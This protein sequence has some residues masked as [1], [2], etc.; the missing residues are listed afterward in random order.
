MIS[1]WHFLVANAPTLVTKLNQHI[2]LSLS[3]TLLAI[4]IGLPLGIW[5]EQKARVRPII[6]GVVNI[7]QTIPSLAL[8]A[9]FIPLLGIG[10]K[11][12]IITLSIYA[13]LPIVRNTYLGLH[14]VPG[15]SIE[16]ARAMGFTRWQRLRI[17][18][19]PLAMPMI[20]AGIR[21]AV[22]MNI[23]ITTIAAFI[24]AGG[25]GDFITEGLAMNNTR[26]ILLGAIPAALLA[27]IADY[28]IAQ[29]EHWA[30]KRARRH[31]R[32]KIVKLGFFMAAFLYFLWLLV[33]TS[34][35]LFSHARENTLIVGGKNFTEQFILTDI[36]G[37][38]LR[39]HTHLHVVLKPNLGS[40]TIA[41][42]ALMSGA[43]DMYPEY[44]GTGYVVVLHQK[45]RLNAQ[46]LFHY[47]N[48]A[49]QKRFKLRWIAPLGFENAQ[50]LALPMAKANALNIHTLSQLTAVAPQLTVGAPPEFLKRADGL[51]GLQ[52]TY[53]LHF[54]KIIEMQTNLMYRAIESHQVDII[55]SFTTDGWLNALHLEPL[56][57]DKHVYPPYYAAIVIREQTLHEHPAL[58][59]TL[60]G[61]AH[62]ISQKTMQH[63][64]YLVVVKHQTPQHV[65]V[66]F[67]HKNN[68]L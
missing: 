9:F 43:I 37:D 20:I 19:L 66:N 50:T 3:S 15:A 26:L 30:S 11:P 58:A 27:L 29:I 32:A 65:A 31:M 48:V 38:Y 7:F 53:H 52:A 40:T 5:V 62:K 4:I 44:T 54:K 2:F 42:E 12:T 23:G 59:H 8:L 35:S 13:L 56:R 45:K 47:V 14:S 24:G 10:I 25:L 33:Q 28:L 36:I 21:I 18:S 46:A 63:L 57:D 61:L 49:Y 6:L 67:L 64:N 68:L 16:A 51:P 17:V 22:A 39:A 1:L 41:Q 34:L 55:E 60:N